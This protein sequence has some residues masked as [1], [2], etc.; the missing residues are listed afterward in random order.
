MKAVAGTIFCDGLSKLLP[1]NFIVRGHALP[2]N[3]SNIKYFQ[4]DVK[5]EV[6]HAVSSSI[7]VQCFVLRELRLR[8]LKAF[9]R[10]YGCSVPHA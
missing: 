8:K 9:F 2:I 1:A 3:Y 7:S 10:I 5:A 4:P 6:L